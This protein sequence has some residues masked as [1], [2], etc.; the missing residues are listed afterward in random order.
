MVDVC[1][2]LIAVTLNQAQAKNIARKI[3]LMAA[4]RPATED[5]V[6]ALGRKVDDDL[7]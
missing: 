6:A 3:G 4:Y 2:N 1:G 7:T 5:D